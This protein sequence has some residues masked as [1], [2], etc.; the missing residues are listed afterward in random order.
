M[1]DEQAPTGEQMAPTE[2]GE[3]TAGTGSNTTPEEQAS[4]AQ[5]YVSAGEFGR[6]FG[7]LETQLQTMM[8]YIAAQQQVASQRQ[9]QIPQG[10][11][12]GT[13]TDEELW[14]AAQTGDRPAFEEYQ[15]RIAR[16][17][18]Q[19]QQQTTG[20]QN[21]VEVQLSALAQKYPV[22]KDS[23]HPLTQKA[24]TAYQL[25]VNN[26]YP[27]NRETL[28]EA[29]K[30]AV[31]DSPDLV[32]EIYSQ[33]SVAREHSRQ[34]GVRSAQSGVTGVSHRQ[35]PSSQQ[36][37]VSVN[38]VEAGL[39]SRMLPYNPRRPDEKTPEQRAAGAKKRFLERQ[40]A[41]LSTI[42]PRML[43]VVERM[44]EDF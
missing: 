4:Q 7:K 36:S 3:Q 44:Q 26:G 30:T 43:P 10:S 15:R 40:Q 25:L 39:A 13:P 14:S 35:S 5:K 11:N 29:A 19:A 41:G 28:L 33:G 24:Q 27:A 9:S 23:S 21:L 22:L 17:E 1:A 12:I 32:S 2:T 31:A 34:S 20:R 42:D 37:R 38:E 16:R 6:R 18:L 8:S